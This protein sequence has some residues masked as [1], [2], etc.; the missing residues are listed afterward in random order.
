MKKNL[1]FLSVLLLVFQTNILKAQG[2]Y[3][4]A[5][6]QP[7]STAIS[8]TDPCFKAWATGIELT[9]GYIMISDPTQL[10]PDSTNKASFGYP[11]KALGIAEGNSL[12]VVSF[13]DAGVALLTF[14][15]PIVNGEGFDFAVF[16][17]GFSDGFLELAFV[18]VSSDGK[19][20]VRFPS[21]SLTQTDTQIDG[22]GTIDPTNIH[23]LAGK[24]RQGYGTPFDLE[25]LKDSTGIDLNN[26]RFV[27]L[28][29]VVGSIDPQYCSYDSRGNIINDPYPA[30][31]ASGGFDLDAVGAI[32]IGTKPFVV[33]NFNNLNLEHDSF[34]NGSD[35]S[36]GFTD[37]ELFYYK[38][39]YEASYG[40]WSGFAYSNMRDD[41]TAGHLNQFS[42]IT[43]GGMDATPEQGTNYAI[44]HVASDWANGYAPI[45]SVVSFNNNKIG[46]VSGMYV[47]NATYAYLSMRD[48]DSYSKKFGGETGNDPDW[49]KL[50][51]WGIN[52]DNE[53]TDTI[54][55]YLADYRFENNEDDYIVDNWRWLDLYDLGYVKSLNFILSSTD[56]GAFGMN[57]PAYFCMDNLV[58]TD[59]KDPQSDGKNLLSHINVEAYPNPTTDRIF[60]VAPENSNIKLIDL[61]GRVIKSFKSYEEVSEINMSDL[62]T[63]TYIVVAEKDN[64]AKHVKVI[65]R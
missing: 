43:A 37:A 8:C 44:S 56:V 51:V 62:K 50:S 52:A 2:P 47:T 22:F 55:F 16:E 25:D 24:Y 63:G 9:R 18:E 32:N 26:I 48:G 19:R 30:D 60:V 54:N 10:G 5:A 21:V 11:S 61:N 23:N 46:K 35:N 31:F 3:P 12:D 39:E 42:A 28:I 53:N 41:S 13:G 27:R 40:S 33:S 49:F 64:F 59:V 7:G 65:K 29:D 36:G 57:T 6:G 34:W 58:V 15:V 14:D 45:P 38:N 17:N 20:F 1:L 4:P